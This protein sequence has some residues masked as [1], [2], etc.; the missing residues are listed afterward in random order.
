M[1]IATSETLVDVSKVEG[2]V[3]ERRSSTF[4]FHGSIP[5]HDLAMQLGDQMPVKEGHKSREG[6]AE[7]GY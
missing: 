5:S 4:L 7:S 3:G 2:K 1:V 6:I